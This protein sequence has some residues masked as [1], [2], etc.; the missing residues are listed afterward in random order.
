M[1][2]IC[3]I[4]DFED[5][6][7]RPSCVTMSEKLR[8]RGPDGNGDFFEGGVCFSHN[9]LAVMDIEYGSQPM[10]ITHEG[11][12]YTIVY[13]GE[14][15]NMPELKKEIEARGIEVKTRCDTELVLWSYII[16]REQ[17]PRKLN[18]IFAFAVYESGEERI[19]LA[20][21]RFGIKPLFYTYVGKRFLF[22]S[23]VKALLA[24]K[25]VK[26]EVDKYGLWELLYLAPVTLPHSAVF[27]GIREL[28]AAECGYVDKKGAHFKKYWRM[29]ARELHQSRD[30][31]IENTRELLV[32]AIERQ[33]VS[34]VPLCT[35]LSGGLDSSIITAV[36]C[37]A[38]K[39][40][41]E[42]L[43]TYSF[44]Y[45]DNEN[46]ER[47]LFQPNRDEDYALWLSEQLGT[48]HTVLTVPTDE[49]VEHLFDAANARDLPGQADIDSS[50]WYFCREVK[51]RHTVALS[52][53]CSDEIF[54][55]YPWFYRPEMLNRSFF[56]WL[57]EPRARIS[58]FDNSLIKADE[59][60]AYISEIYRKSVSEADTL[61]SDSAEMKNS[62][63]ATCLSVHYFM[64]NLLAR[65]DRMSMAN[66]LEVR[67]PFGDHRILEYVYNVPWS[68]KFE[69][70]VEKALLRQA[71]KDYLPE[72][73]IN[74][75]KSPYPK[76]H[77]PKYEEKVKELLFSRLSD[78]NCRLREIIS[79]KKLREFADGED[80]TW[81][82][83]LMSRAQLFAWLIELDAW[84]E[85]YS[86]EIKN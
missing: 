19:F 49:L 2:S 14:L 11:K 83:Q 9:R 72:R 60:Y 12:K 17:C 73:I 7:I 68:I 3:G 27:R 6:N 30:E 4:F 84:F 43:C 34:D 67:V 15:Y 16:W 26:A 20:R 31:I 39:R 44:E 47:N 76:T 40:R 18:G 63:I 8:H 78:K 37:E 65:K 86:V 57:H 45:E 10:S 53:E 25:G 59:G 23:E 54:G 85:Y 66:A 33:L 35:F 74:R 5:N 38:Y 41:G 58:L 51:K 70:G 42:K 64:S 69:N 32:D 61:E 13:N 62:R 77:S 79:E 82:G 24:H 48:E 29:E 36:A 22:A 56:P 21:D 81:F 28:G 1:C 55:G 46:F 71:M 52:G 80:K 75:K 50:L